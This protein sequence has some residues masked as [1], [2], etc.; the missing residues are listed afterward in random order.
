[1]ARSADSIGRRALDPFRGRLRRRCAGEVLDDL[2]EVAQGRR[3]LARFFEV[4]PQPQQR[5]CT[6]GFLRCGRLV[7]LFVGCRLG[8]L[9]RFRGRGVRDVLGRHLLLRR[10]GRSTL[11]GGSLRSNPSRRHHWRRHRQTGPTR[12]GAGWPLFVLPVCKPSIRLAFLMY[13]SGF[14]LNSSRQPVQQI[15]KVRPW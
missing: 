7:G 12:E 1:M 13:F 5:R 10:L 3:R 9:F 15:G 14:S 2:P 8:W 11:A 4:L 6:G